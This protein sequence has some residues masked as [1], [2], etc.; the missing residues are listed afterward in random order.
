MTVNSVDF[1]E[2]VQQ[3]ANVESPPPLAIERFATAP[4][5]D[6]GAGLGALDEL[7]NEARALALRG[8]SPRA[9]GRGA[10]AAALD[11]YFAEAKRILERELATRSRGSHAAPSAQNFGP[12]SKLDLRLL[13]PAE[14]TVFRQLV[15]GKPNKI[16]AW[17]LALSEATVKAHVSKILKKLKVRNRGHA[18]ALCLNQQRVAV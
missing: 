2:P 12:E 16:I 5:A 7:A 14:T 11:A 3:V 10:L 9:S 15:K 17:E 4:A 1:C 8:N 13:S 6:R 18:I